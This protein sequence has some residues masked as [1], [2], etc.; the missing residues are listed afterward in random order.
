[1]PTDIIRP[2]CDKQSDAD[3]RRPVD[4]Q[5]LALDALSKLTRQFCDKPDFERLIDVLMM[6][7]CGQFSVADVFALL[8]KPS[9]YSLNQSFFAT[10]RFKRDVMLAS[11]QVASVDLEDTLRI[12]HVRKVSEFEPSSESTD[13]LPVLVSAGVN[14]V[15]PLIHNDT[16]FGIIGLGNRVTGKTYA[17]EDIEL[18]NTIINTVTPLVANSYLFWDI[19]SLNAWYLDILNNVKQ[20]VFVFDRD[21]RLKKVNS[22]GLDI[23]RTFRSDDVRLADL[24]NGPIEHVFPESVFDGWAKQFS[25]AKAGRRKALIGSIVASSAGN[26]RIYNVSITGSVE[27]TEIGSALIITLDD[28]TIQKES[29][30]RL[31]D[32]QKFADKGLMASSIAHELNNFLALI[33]GGV[34]VIEIALEDKDREKALETIGKLKNNIENMERFTRGL[35]D[36]AR[37]ESDKEVLNL[38]TVIGDVLSFLSVQKRFKWVKIIAELDPEL[39]D[40]QIDKDQIAQLLLNLLN[41]G[42]DAIEESG[43]KEGR[44]TI[45][46]EDEDRYALLTVSD[47]GIGM[48]EDVRKRLFRSSFT[49]KQSGHG[50]GLVTCAKIVEDHGGKIAVDTKP[51]RGT[52]FTIRLPK[53]ARTY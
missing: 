50:Y 23:L 47:N 45:T 19:A 11:L 14:L 21:C 12:G 3:V 46:T 10:G 28:V 43:E 25:S 2:T 26:E 53:H 22:A 49:T 44:I 13:L 38:N 17:Q 34:E 5:I 31:F 27:N 37:L 7:L 16:F 29:E 42:A 51:G 15:C 24:E 41:N 35:T 18:L 36:L 48:K 1:M 40:L 32:L 52:T 39:P 8:K 6:T 9:S 4:K 33:L 20:G 30:Q